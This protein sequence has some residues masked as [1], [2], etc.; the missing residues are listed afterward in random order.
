MRASKHIL[1]EAK[2]V[3]D[4]P[5]SDLHSTL[6][7]YA[8]AFSNTHRHPDFVA[9]ANEHPDQHLNSDADQHTN[10]NTHANCDG[11]ATDPEPEACLLG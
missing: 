1:A 2:A 10:A 9:H 8:G 7:T 11:S 6:H 3:G 5:F 4:N